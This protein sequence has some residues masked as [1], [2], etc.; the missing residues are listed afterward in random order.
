[1]DTIGQ[2]DGR[3]L[4]VPRGSSSPALPGPNKTGLSNCSSGLGLSTSRQ[5]LHATFAAILPPICASEQVWHET[6]NPPFSPMD[7]GAAGRTRGIQQGG[8]GQPA[9]VAAS[10]A[11]LF[12]P[13]GLLWRGRVAPTGALVQR[14]TECLRQ[15][16]VAWERAGLRSPAPSPAGPAQGWREQHAVPS[17]LAL[18]VYT[19]E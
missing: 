11:A 10:S 1:L 17:R 6:H 19:P 4:F 16:G 3:R 13:T 2:E 14:P 12:D 9:R 5:N 7:T 15:A 8:L 18:R